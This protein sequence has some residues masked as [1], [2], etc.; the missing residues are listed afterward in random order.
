MGI[1]IITPQAR[2]PQY[3]WLRVRGREV[4]LYRAFGVRLFARLLEA[5]GWNR[6]LA[7]ERGFDGGRGGLKDLDQHTHR[8]EIS[9]IICLIITIMLSL[10]ALA[11]GSWAGAIWLIALG[12]PL[13]LYPALLQRLIRARIQAVAAT[14]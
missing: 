13:H 2:L 5:I 6:L 4:Q 9:H 11:T 8:S 14:Y 3:D 12:V 10:A 7:R 1:A